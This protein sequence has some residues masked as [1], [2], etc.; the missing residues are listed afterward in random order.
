MRMFLSNPLLPEVRAQFDLGTAALDD[1][2]L[3]T[4]QQDQGACETLWEVIRSNGTDL[5]ANDEIAFYRSGDRYFVPIY[6]RGRDPRPNI[7]R[8]DG[9]NSL[10]VYD[11]EFRLIGRF[12]A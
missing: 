2:R 10:D 8:F 1:I 7:I 5:A 3:L 11:S 12:K 9:N 4:M 6:R